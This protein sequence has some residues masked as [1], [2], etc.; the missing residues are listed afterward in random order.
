MGGNGFLAV[1]KMGELR[2]GRTA[3]DAVLGGQSG[4]TG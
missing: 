3:G 2:G 1:A 4:F